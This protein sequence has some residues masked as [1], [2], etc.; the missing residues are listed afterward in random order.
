MW[1]DCRDTPREDV[2]VDRNI[3]APRRRGVASE[4]VRRHNLAAIL[5]PLHL[6]GPR[7]RS[8][9]SALTGLNRSTVGGLVSELVGL[10]LVE[11]EPGV[12]TSGPGRPSSV[13]RT[14]ETAA[15]VVA[16]ELEVE[17]VA[18]ALVGLG[19]HIFGRTRERTP[20]G[21]DDPQRLVGRV[22]ALSS[23]LLGEL[24][25]GSRIVGAGVGVAG[26]VRRHDGFVHTAPNLGWSS[27]PI[28]RMISEE[29]GLEIVR[30]ANEADLGAL[31]EFRRGAGRR[32]RDLVFVAGE[33]GLGL[34]I[35][36]DA[37]PMLGRF[38]YAGEAGHSVINP[39]GRPCRCG[40]TGC[41]ETEVGEEALRERA[42]LADWN[43]TDPIEEI[44]R[45]HEDGDARTVGAV[46]E[47]GRWL[48]LGIGGLINVFNPE[49]VVVGGFLHALYPAMAGAI[50]TAARSV[51]LDAPWE[52][53]RIVPSALG[54]DALTVGA[55]ELVFGEV[56]ADPTAHVTGA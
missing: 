25:D 48:G 27:V 38:G 32:T 40:A 28:G 11:E 8:E 9:L 24:P 47:E 52:A 20:S 22:A 39:D 1:V 49:L 34:G 50:E 12:P 15:V 45:R 3:T 51:A 4:E 16:V 53:C 29:L 26:V 14:V 42:G 37:K 19:G 55:A 7:S 31:G 2:T 21:R 41:W 17:S 54:D 56:I 46:E 5:E 10:G 36:H 18:V 44:L 23:E 13:A 43:G 30:V 35:I 6:T 33:V